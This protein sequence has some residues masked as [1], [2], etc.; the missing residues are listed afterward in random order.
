M[1]RCRRTHRLSI[2]GA[3]SAWA[4]GGDTALVVSPKS[5]TWDGVGADITAEAVP[6]ADERQ[7][8]RIIVLERRK[9]IRCPTPPAG[10]CGIGAVGSIQLSLCL[11][12]CDIPG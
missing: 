11:P 1:V 10:D 8:Q 6:N 2:W 4:M 3:C 12:V 5:G 7:K 9:E